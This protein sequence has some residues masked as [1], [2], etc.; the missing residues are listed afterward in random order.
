MRLSQMTDPAIEAMLAE[1]T[2]EVMLIF[3]DLVI[4][5]STTLYV[6]NNW[7]AVTRGGNSYLPYRFTIGLPNEV[8]EGL[9]SVPFQI[10]NVD[11]ILI[12]SLL[13]LTAPID[14]EMNAALASSPNTSEAGPFNLKAGDFR[15]TDKHITAELTFDDVML[16]SYPGYRVQPSN[17]PAAF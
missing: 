6:V 12:E 2:G 11:V 15:W 13:T 8:D 14:V 17:H 7:E 10:D 1:E 9:P 16:E 4:D 3:L 5:G